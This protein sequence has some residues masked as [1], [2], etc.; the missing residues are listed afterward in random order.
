MMVLKLTGEEE[1]IAKQPSD[2]RNQH[3]VTKEIWK[4]VVIQVLYQTSVSMILEFGGDVTDKEKK[5]RETMIFN[6][7]LFCQLCNFLNYQVLKMVVQS[8]YFL[9][10]M[11][12][13][14]LLQ[15]LV[16]EYA[17]GLADC[18]QLNAI[19][20][21]ISVLIGALACVFEWTLKIIILPFILNP[22]TNINI[23]S[24]SITSPSFYLSPV[25]P[26]LMMFVLF[27][28]G[29]IFSQIGMNM[30]IR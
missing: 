11:G 30:T 20:W 26:I 27:P 15:V 4:N 21:G 13:C 3:I 6:T 22:S 16:I 1:Q 19:R 7:F 18:M 17:K 14:F 23:A 10:A 2:H 9:V 25:F 24:E 28:V 8:F 29:L 12:G 5:V